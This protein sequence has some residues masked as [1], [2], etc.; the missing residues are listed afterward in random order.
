MS[1]PKRRH[2]RARMRARAR[3]LLKIENYGFYV[4][5]EYFEHWVRVRGNTFSVCSCPGC[6]NPRRWGKWSL[7]AYGRLTLQERKSAITHAE[8]MP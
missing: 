8:S 3:A 1:I 5:P 4:D 6:G 2:H 7:S